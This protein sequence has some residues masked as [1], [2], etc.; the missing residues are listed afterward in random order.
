MALSHALGHIGLGSRIGPEPAD[1]NDV[2]GA[3]GGSV[4]PSIEAVARR[5]AG[6]GWDWADTA[7]R[8]K[9]GLRV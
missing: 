6:R 1:G 8:G 5:L 9:A 4:A 3:V 7:K 2:Q